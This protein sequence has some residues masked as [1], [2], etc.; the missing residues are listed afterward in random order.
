MFAVNVLVCYLEKCYMQYQ[1]CLNVINHEYSFLT[2]NCSSE[3]TY[4]VWYILNNQ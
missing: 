2:N 3:N 4:N 1:F